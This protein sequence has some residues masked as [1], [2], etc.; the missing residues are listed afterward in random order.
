MRYVVEQIDSGSPFTIESTII[1][2]SSV[3]DVISNTTIITNEDL[4][5]FYSNLKQMETINND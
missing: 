2:V 1:N 4:N 5:N 3:S